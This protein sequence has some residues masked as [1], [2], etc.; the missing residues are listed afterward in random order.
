VGALERT[1]R[2]KYL[3]IVSKVPPATL[4]ALKTEVGG[5]AAEKGRT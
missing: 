5:Q 2:G 1:G 4:A 3:S